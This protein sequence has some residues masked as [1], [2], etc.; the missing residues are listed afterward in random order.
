VLLLHV[1]NAGWLLHQ[2]LLPGVQIIE[3]WLTVNLLNLL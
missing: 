3:Q 2:W 1:A